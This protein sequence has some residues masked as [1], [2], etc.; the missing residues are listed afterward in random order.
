MIK[1]PL[2]NRRLLRKLEQ[3]VRLMAPHD[4][5][6]FLG[7]FVEDATFVELSHLHSI[8]VADVEAALCRG[9]AVLA[10]VLEPEPPRWRPF[11]RR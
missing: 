4:R 8:S 6:I 5:A 1:L 7:H 3:A 2:K 9:L 10:D 11:W